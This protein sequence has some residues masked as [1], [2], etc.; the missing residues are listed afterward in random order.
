M[1]TPIYKDGE[2][3]KFS[4]TLFNKSSQKL[5]FVRYNLPKEKT[6]SFLYKLLKILLSLLLF[7]KRQKKLTVKPTKQEKLKTVLTCTFI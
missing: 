3:T 2:T 4:F 6:N 7:N 5:P 1:C